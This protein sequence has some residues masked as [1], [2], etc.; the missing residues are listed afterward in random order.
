M[1]V[2]KNKRNRKYFTFP[3]WRLTSKE[4]KK[5]YNYYSIYLYILIY[6]KYKDKKLILINIWWILPPIFGEVKQVDNMYL[7]N[8]PFHFLFLPTKYAS[9]AFPINKSLLPLPSFFFSTITN[10][11]QKWESN[12]QGKVFFLKSFFFLNIHGTYINTR[13]DNLNS[14]L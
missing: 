3:L 8:F 5:S 6:F 4:K 11:T 14:I 12:S 2:K 13:V 7:P 1:K 10:I 9:L